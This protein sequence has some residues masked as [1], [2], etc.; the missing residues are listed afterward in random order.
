MLLAIQPLIPGES[1]DFV[2]TTKIKYSIQFFDLKVSR[3]LGKEEEEMYSID[4]SESVAMSKVKAPVPKANRP[5][6]KVK[7]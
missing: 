1:I 2:V 7:K 3:S 4:D 5:E 6:S